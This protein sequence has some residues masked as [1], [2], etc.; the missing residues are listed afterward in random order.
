[1]LASQSFDR[2]QEGMDLHIRITRIDNGR[3]SYS[4]IS[5]AALRRR[6]GT[7]DVLELSDDGSLLI[8]G[9]EEHVFWS[10]TK[11]DEERKA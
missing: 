10:S 3:Q 8:N 5:G 9:K 6:I 2:E 4:Y 7:D 1:M 11:N